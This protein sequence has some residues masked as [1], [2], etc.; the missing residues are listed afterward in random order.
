MKI[1]S[2][3]RSRLKRLSVEGISLESLRDRWPRL[4]VSES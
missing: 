4:T 2:G 3:S 1:E